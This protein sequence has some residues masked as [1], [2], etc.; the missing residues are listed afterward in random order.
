MLGLGHKR[1]APPEVDEMTAR[2]EPIE[3]ASASAQVR[4]VYDDIMATRKSDWVNNFWK[5]LRTTRRHCSGSG[6]TSSR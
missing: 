3:Y 4:A 5:V 1:G 6:A 2:R